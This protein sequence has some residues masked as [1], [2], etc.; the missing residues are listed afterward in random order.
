[1][2][3]KRSRHRQLT[4]AALV[5]LSLVFVGCSS[6]S[7]TGKPAPTNSSVS[8]T[9]DAKNSMTGP[10]AAYMGIDIEANE[11]QFA[12]KE[13]R[14]Q[15]LVVACM[16]EEGFDYKPQD[17]G[18]SM[19]SSVQYHPDDPEWVGKF[20][21]GISTSDELHSSAPVHRDPN[22][23]ML[24]A[25]SDSEREAYYQALYGTSP[26]SGSMMAS[27]VLVET[28]AA[29]G[30]PNGEAATSGEP[31]SPSTA[32]TSPA[33][34]ASTPADSSDTSSDSQH[35]TPSATGS[36]EGCQNKAQQEIHG[37][38]GQQNYE[39]FNEMF[40]D[41]QAMGQRFENDPRIL[42]EYEKWTSCMSNAG[43]PGLTKP[44]DAREQV[45]QAWSRLNGWGYS[46]TDA[47]G[48]QI[49]VVTAAAQ[50]TTPALDA[51]TAFRQ[52]EIATALAD[53]ECMKPLQEPLQKIRFEYEQTFVEAHRAELE[54]YR[55]VIGTGGR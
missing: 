6:Q 11:K 27:A 53:L 33:T 21:Y 46:T 13:R 35:A 39:Q 19:A 3:P 31:D 16:R 22:K 1:M 47:D 38:Q 18:D 54:R 30:D 41:M 34:T 36:Q 14:V 26:G 45:Q 29:T 15:E 23:D 5:C 7:G 32:E 49:D 52:T 24:D 42:Q 17:P 20:G 4:L 55:E 51:V 40:E 25:M 28:E 43:Y 8:G 2:Y 48:H 50:P 44:Y 12:E 37:D 9:S 10:L